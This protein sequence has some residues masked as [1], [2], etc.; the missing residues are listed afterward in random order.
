[1]WTKQ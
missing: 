1:V